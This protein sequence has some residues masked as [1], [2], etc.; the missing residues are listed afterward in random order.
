MWHLLSLFRQNNFWHGVGY[1]AWSPFSLDDFTHEVVN[2]S[3]LT[4]YF[5]HRFLHPHLIRGQ[6]TLL[7]FNLIGEPVGL[8]CLFQLSLLGKSIALLLHIE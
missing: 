7:I 3:F 2:Y 8:S 4:T 5:F 6:A 1:I